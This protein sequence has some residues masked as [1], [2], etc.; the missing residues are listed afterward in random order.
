M[1][2]TISYEFLARVQGFD[3]VAD[4]RFGSYSGDYVVIYKDPLHEYNLTT[5]KY[6][7]HVG[8]LVIGFGS[9]SGCDELEAVNWIDEDE[10]WW[11]VGGI[12]EI[13]T[14]M[15]RDIKWYSSTEVLEAHMLIQNP[16]HWHDDAIKSF[17]RENVAEALS[18]SV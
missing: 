2:K 10:L 17:I 8:V 7:P 1:H 6:I 9:C 14:R 5:H 3:V 16:W 11:D 15:H 4:E 18:A 13:A 12:R